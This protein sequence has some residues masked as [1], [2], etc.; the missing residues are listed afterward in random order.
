MPKIKINK[1]DVLEYREGSGE[2]VEI[3]DIKVMSERKIGNGTKLFMKLLELNPRFVYAFTREGNTIARAFY[4]K[5]GFREQKIKKMYKDENAILITYE[6]T[7][8]R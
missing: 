1:I 4:K 5:L 6:N 3:F 2:T 8:H 7:L